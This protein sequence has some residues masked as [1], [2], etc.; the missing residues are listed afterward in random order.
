MLEFLCSQLICPQCVCCGS[1]QVESHFYCL[2][3]FD[4]I[5]KKHA[6]FEK[7]RI[8]FDNRFLHVLTLLSW[9]PYR[10]DSLSQVAYLL[11]SRFSYYGWKRYT[12]KLM[13]EFV[14]LCRLQPE[15]IIPVP[16]SQRQSFHTKYFSSALA[17]KW[18]GSCVMT[19]LRKK[20][21]FQQKQRQS[22]AIRLNVEMEFNVDFTYRIRKAKKIVL[23]DDIITTGTT[24][25]AC[26]LALQPY[27]DKD[28]EIHIIALLSREKI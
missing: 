7:R 19:C 12:E 26:L 18:E 4:F 24:I 17:E 14:E 13:Y 1:L 22:R 9:V 5:I 27:L 23:V 10:S 3:C 28:C 21:S 8:H 15:I 16:G 25:N 6:S 2:R 20:T 11:K